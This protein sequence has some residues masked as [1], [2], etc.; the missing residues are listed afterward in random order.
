MCGIQEIAEG[1]FAVVNGILNLETFKPIGNFTV[2]HVEMMAHGATVNDI[3]RLPDAGLPNGLTVT[4]T[5][6]VTTAGPIVLVANSFAGCVWKVNTET[7]A[8]TKSIDDQS[9][10]AGDMSPVGI[11]GVP[12]KDGA[13]CYTN[14]GLCP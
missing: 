14:L 4:V 10:K 3:A 7:A 11:N 12:V 5:S 2:W 6:L 13:L 9:M 8:I 1:V